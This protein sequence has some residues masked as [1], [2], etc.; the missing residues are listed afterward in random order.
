MT[1]DKTDLRPTNPV[2]LPQ[3]KD[4]T[5]P[6]NSFIIWGAGGGGAKALQLMRE[7]CAPVTAFIDSNPTLAGTSIDGI[8]V[9]PPTELATVRNKNETI[10]IASIHH[11]EIGKT[12]LGLGLRPEA[13]FISFDEYQCIFSP[14]G[15]YPPAVF[16]NKA[17]QTLKQF[18]RIKGVSVLHIGSGP[19]LGVDIALLLAGA[20]SV[21]AIDILSNLKF[22]DISASCFY[23]EDFLNELVASPDFQ[24]HC[25]YPHPIPWGH[26]FTATASGTAINT[27]RLQYHHCSAAS[28]PAAENSYDYVFSNAVME[29]LADPATVIKE[30]KRVLKPDGVTFHNID[31]RDHSDFTNPY[32]HL[33]ISREE[34]RWRQ[35]PHD[36]CSGNQARAIDFFHWFQQAG[37]TIAAYSPSMKN[38]ATPYTPLDTARLHSDFAAY[39]RTEI[40]ALGCFIKATKPRR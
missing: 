9:H 40:E 30:I 17:T 29:H 3:G 4:K 28:I 39:S 25:V 37:L 2:I 5:A 34:W 18:D 33:Y 24:P 6:Q 12:L 38:N 10:V 16:V 26:F 1:A 22:P 32:A 11:Q 21:T 13:D 20:A 15:S 7:Q 23:Y 19:F 14:G 8:P 35:A 27:D 36:F 31:L